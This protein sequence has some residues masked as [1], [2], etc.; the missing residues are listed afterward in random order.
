MWLSIVRGILSLPRVHH[1][2]KRENGNN[3]QA[4]GN[5]WR[6]NRAVQDRKSIV[7]AAKLISAQKVIQ[8]VIVTL[9]S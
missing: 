3:E 6:I 5:S 9:V 2:G 1:N 8:Y 7:K 4:T